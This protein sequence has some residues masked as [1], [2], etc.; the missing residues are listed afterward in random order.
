MSPTGDR[1]SDVRRMAVRQAPGPIRA[2]LQ[3][4]SAPGPAATQVRAGPPGPAIPLLA[5]PPKG[6]ESS[7]RRAP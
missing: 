1:S 5:R 4:L 3:Y 7:S 2:D 6:A